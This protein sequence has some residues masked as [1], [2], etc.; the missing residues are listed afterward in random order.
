VQIEKRLLNIRELSAYISMPVPTIYT[1]VS[2]GKIPSDCIVRIGRALKF[3]KA[4]V[5]GWVSEAAG[6]GAS[7]RPG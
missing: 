6:T 7:S 4:A 5:D 1:Y 2:L 3:E